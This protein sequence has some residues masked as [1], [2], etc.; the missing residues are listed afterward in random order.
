MASDLA[1]HGIRAWVDD[2]EIRAGDS[3]VKRLSEAIDQADYVLV[4]LS[5]ASVNSVWVKSE[6]SA[7]FTKDP[8]GAKRILIPLIIEPVE[9]PPFMRDI[10]YVDFSKAPY[11]KALDKIVDSI[12][13][14]SDEK[15]PAP[16]ELINTGNL[17]REIAKEV[18]K[19]ITVDSKGIRIDDVSSASKNL[20]SSVAEWISL[21]LVAWIFASLVFGGYVISLVAAL[22]QPAVGYGLAI[23]IISAYL[24]NM[25]FPIAMSIF[26]WMIAS[27]IMFI[28]QVL[29]KPIQWIGVVIGGGSMLLSML[30][31]GTTWMSL[32]A[33]HVSWF[34]GFLDLEMPTK[35]VVAFVCIVAL[36]YVILGPRFWYRTRQPSESLGAKKD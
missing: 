18:A 31:L 20:R 29:V 9:I 33:T 36:A 19:L 5:Q 25:V 2:V 21:R 16:A 1:A 7:A 26:A 10:Q 8:A 28:R 6:V 15:K 3:I 4:V 22:F 14:F 13:K 27:V 17:A 35:L 23:Y 11:Q 32:S 34:V 30:T 24:A 12:Q